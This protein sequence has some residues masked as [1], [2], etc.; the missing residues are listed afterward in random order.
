MAVGDLVQHLA[1]R[2]VATRG[3]TSKDISD[4]LRWEV[5]R[6]RVRRVGR[7]T[8]QVGHVARQTVWRMRRRVA[9]ALPDCR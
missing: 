7:A 5:A 1:G 9:E 3:R 8:Y 4:A 2:G 6:G